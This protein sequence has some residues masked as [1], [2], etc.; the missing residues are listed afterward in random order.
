MQDIHYPKQMKPTCPYSLCGELVYHTWL[1]DGSWDGG[2]SSAYWF[3]FSGRI[4]MLYLQ[5]L[6]MYHLMYPLCPK[7]PLCYKNIE[8]V[9]IFQCHPRCWFF[10]LCNREAW[11]AAI[12]G[13][14]KSRTRLSDWTEL[15]GKVSTDSEHFHVYLVCSSG[16]QKG[17]LNGWMYHQCWY[18]LT[19]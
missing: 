3:S 11:H 17:G 7:F 8:L 19:V 14:A 18:C 13:V 10:F 12:H 2:L 9:E 15:K 5:K 4:V 6:F 1:S 16:G